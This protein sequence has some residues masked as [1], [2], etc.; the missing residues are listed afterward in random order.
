MSTAAAN[1]LTQGPIFSKIIRLAVPIAIGMVF[2]TL[3]HLV[4]LYFVS[5]L[6]DAAI[7]GVSAAGNVQFLVVALTQILG[8]GTMVLIAQAVGA[9]RP[10]DANLIFNQSLVLGGGC[11]LAMVLG[12]YLVV[13]DYMSILGADPATEAAG[14]EYLRWFLPGLALQFAAVTMSSALRGTGIEKPTMIVQVCSVVLN[15]LLSPMLIAGWL[16]GRPMG[17]AG[18]GLASTLSI[19]VGVIAMGLYFH[20]TKKSVQVDRQLLWPRLAAWRQILGIG[21]PA[22]GQFALLFVYVTVSY[23]VIR[24][25]GAAAQAGFGI[26]SRVMQSIFLPAMAVAFAAA[27]VAGQNFGA[28]EFARVRATFRSAVWMGSSLMLVLTLLCQWDPELLVRGFTS[29]PQVIAV[30]GQFLRIISWNFVASGLVFTCS[31]LFQAVGNTLPA[32]LA[33]ATRLLTFVPAAILLSRQP[34]FGLRHLWFLS[35]ATV[36]LQAITALLLLRLELRRKLAEGV[37]GP[38]PPASG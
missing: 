10:G 27:P 5:R 31:S 35:V 26:G 29:D 30:G 18:A 9:K 25:F 4:D 2:Q 7:A 13:G 3:Y 19:T 1:D 36:S 16:T 32:L 15:A 17:V 23:W 24:G 20:R 33:S 8:V 38:M 28:G 21:L 12:G 34:S 14:T 37:V 11:A 6:G 22:G